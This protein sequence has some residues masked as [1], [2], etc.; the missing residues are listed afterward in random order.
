[1]LLFRDAV[2][3]NRSARH[4]GPTEQQGTGTMGM[5]ID[6]GSVCFRRRFHM[7]AYAE[8]GAP[9]A[10]GPSSASTA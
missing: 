3:V 2:T 6:S 8:W 5:R 4:H 10:G 7:M 9:S 1:M